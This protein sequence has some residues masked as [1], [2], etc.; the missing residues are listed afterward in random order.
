MVDSAAGPRIARCRGPGSSIRSGQRHAERNAM[1]FTRMA[2]I[3]TMIFAAILGTG[4]SFLFVNGPPRDHERRASFTCTESNAWPVVDAIWAG[5]NG[6]GAASAAN[7]EMNPDKDQIIAVGVGWLLVSGISAVYGFGKVSD[8]KTATGH[9]DERVRRVY[10]PDAEP[11]PRATKPAAR[12]VAPSHPAPSP[13]PAA[14]GPPTAAPVPP[15][16]A[17]APPTAPAPPPAAPAPPTA[18]PAPPPAAGT[19]TGND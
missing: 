2:W 15:T 10:D 5:L 16:A 13:A 6:I 7:D 11:V 4:C 12:P 18:A 17:P 8:C 9:R 3:G 1:G 19:P 14:A